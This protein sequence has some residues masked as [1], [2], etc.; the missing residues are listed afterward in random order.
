[1]GKKLLVSHQSALL[2]YRAAGSGLITPPSNYAASL[3]PSDC[4]TQTHLFKD[5]GNIQSLSDA[6]TLHLTALDHRGLHKVKGCCIHVLT[7][8]LPDGS[9]RSLGNDILVSSPAL[10][11]LQFCQDIAS[12]S[13][14]RSASPWCYDLIEEFGSFG[15][16]AAA[17]EVASELCGSYSI[18]PDGK[19]SLSSHDPFTNVKTLQLFLGSVRRRRQARLARSAVNAASPLSASPR[20]TQLYLEMTL[21]WPI[22]YG[23]PKA[24][25][26][27]PIAIKD[28]LNN[29]AQ[30]HSAIR[31]SDYFWD[32]KT[33]RN[34]RVRRPVTLEYDSD[35]F[36]TAS[37]EV[38][39]ARLAD[40]A[41]RRDQIEAAENHY[42]RITTAHTK[43]FDA[44]DYK[45]RQ[46]ASLLR[47]DLPNRSSGELKLAHRFFE[48]IFNSSRL[49]KVGFFHQQPY[50]TVQ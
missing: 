2:V 21:P 26:N 14:R 45:M 7:G 20:E 4:S 8:S 24:S 46:L 31:F 40:Q 23:L 9:F 3:R 38:T 19:G 48:M 34:G 37:A 18:A 16:L 22:G 10:T 30:D 32:K 11:L 50:P 33:L 27:H 43:D 15:L 47:I 42:L 6:G 25:T 1:M 29:D 39:D 35:E 17:A 5:S 28:P 12:S 41:E 44:F 36:H 49:S 13:R